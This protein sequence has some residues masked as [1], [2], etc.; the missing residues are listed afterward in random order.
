MEGLIHG[1]WG[2]FFKFYGIWRVVLVV[3]SLLCSERFLAEQE[4]L[5]TSF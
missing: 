1:L 4:F 2:F 3:G 5:F